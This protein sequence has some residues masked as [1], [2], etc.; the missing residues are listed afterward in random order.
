MGTEVLN[1]SDIDALLNAAS[2]P[3]PPPAEA[4]PTQIFSRSRRDREKIEIQSYDFKR[5]ERIS[6]DQ[7]R[8]LQMLH[9]TFA[10]NFGAAL[11]GHLRTIV[12][13]S[14]R[15]ASQK[16]YSEFVAESENPTSFNLVRC[17]P[18]EGQIC[19][20]ISP[21]V[22]FPIIDRLLGGSNKDLFIPRRPMTLIETRLIQRI[23]HRAMVA[24]TEAWQGIRKIEFT[25]G[26]MESNAQ[27]VQIVPPNEVVVVVEFEVK[28]MNRGG[29]M[30]LCIPYNSIEPLV[31]D[32]SAQ[33]WFVSGKGATETSAAERIASSLAGA[34]VELDATLATTTISVAEL[35]HLE[36]GD[37]IVTQRPA[38]STVVLGVQ[39]RP[40]FLAELGQLRGNRALRVVRAV[41]RAERIDLGAAGPGRETK[42]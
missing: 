9:E 13:V 24:L 5:P 15:D 31:E 42:P 34:H 36:V 37:L 4:P 1:Q 23:L 40:K 12:E 35:R 27:L 7:M 22:I 28:L 30:R 14:V 38:S 16:T 19:L 18:L 11:S 39:G 33:S 3:A 8:A 41:G 10:R 21:L 2:E 17:P 29:R 32:L 6:K 26:E 20:E 25:L